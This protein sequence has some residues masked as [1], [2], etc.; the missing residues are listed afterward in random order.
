MRD[1]TSWRAQTVELRANE[2]ACS[3][4][5][6]ALAEVS[7]RVRVEREKYAAQGRTVD[8]VVKEE[9]AATRLA[10]RAR[11]ERLTGRV[12]ALADG[13]R[14]RIFGPEIVDNTEL[15]RFNAYDVLLDRLL[16]EFQ[17]IEVWGYSLTALI[18]HEHFVDVVSH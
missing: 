2:Q 10:E 12:K 1:A 17:H 14:L 8:L 9:D 16:V 6:A 15:L 3:S 13:R 18:V 4:A 7:V 5:E 11:Q